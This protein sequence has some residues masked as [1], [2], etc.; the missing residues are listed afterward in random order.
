MLVGL[1]EG[2]GPLPRLHPRGWG[3]LRPPR[4]AF[5]AG[6]TGNSPPIT[7]WGVRAHPALKILPGRG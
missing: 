6:G 4:A 5:G 2:R 7:P 1:C 3:W